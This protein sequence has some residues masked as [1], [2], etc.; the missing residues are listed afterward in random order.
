MGSFLTQKRQ[1]SKPKMQEK[2]QDEARTIDTEKW[3]QSRALGQTTVRRE[4][5]LF[6]RSWFTSIDVDGSGSIS[7]NELLDSL[8]AT[9][10]LDAGWVDYNKQVES[11]M[12]LIDLNGNGELD[13]KEMIRVGMK[14]VPSHSIMSSPFSCMSLTTN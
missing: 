3:M 11:I 5:K 14:I 12:K 10:S 8:L 6:L 7:C 2:I 13:F 9:G 4:E 1:F